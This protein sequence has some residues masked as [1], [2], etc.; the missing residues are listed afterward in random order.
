VF[1]FEDLVGG[2]HRAAIRL[3]P[4]WFAGTGAHGN[5]NVLGAQRPLAV[6]RIDAQ[7]VGGDKR[8]AAVQQ[9]HVIASQGILNNAALAL[10]HAPHM[11]DQLAHGWTWS[12]RVGKR[13]SQFQPW[14]GIHA[15][16]RLTEGF[17]G[18]GAGFNA[19]STDIPLFFNDGDL[20]PQLGRLNGRPLPCWTTA[21]A[22]EIVLV[23]LLHDVPLCA[24]G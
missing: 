11:A 18:N 15:S 16:H 5:Q 9:G 14:T 10:D 7:S 8:G 24:R 19:H 17:G 13:L 22:D 21:N 2:D 3:H 6:H 12:G 20:F 1:Q 23:L 4:L